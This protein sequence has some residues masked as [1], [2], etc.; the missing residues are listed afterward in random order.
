[1]ETK[2]QEYYDAIKQRFAEE[3]HPLGVVAQPVGAELHLERRLL[4]AHI[5][6]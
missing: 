5:Q 4:A 2:T 3:R 1:M 6:R